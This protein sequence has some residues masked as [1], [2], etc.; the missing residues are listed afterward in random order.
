MDFSKIG[1][2][3]I[4]YSYSKISTFDACPAMF[5]YQY[6]KKVSVPSIPIR[7]LE[8]GKYLHSLLEKYLILK[9]ANK[10]LS[11]D[12]VIEIKRYFNKSLDYPTNFIECVDECDNII[13]KLLSSQLFQDTLSNI[14]LIMPEMR[15]TC[16][17]ENKLVLQGYVDLLGLSCRNNELCSIIIDWK[18]GRTINYSGRQVVLYYLML[19]ENVKID[20]CSM[21]YYLIEQDKVE[22]VDL[23]SE[24]YK[25]KIEEV[26]EWVYKTTTELST[27]EVFP[28]N[29]EDYLQCKWCDYKDICSFDE[30]RE[31]SSN[32]QKLLTG[33]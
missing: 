14:D 21:L 17:H 7:A 31:V 12:P 20:N 19:K 1:K 9:N 33:S 6:V 8:R 25:N 16:Y 11:G 10:D 4:P 22:K 5:Y 24:E 2:K 18:S 30:D 27:T 23:F 3:Y 26:K 32:I 29:K 13:R 28:R 15:L